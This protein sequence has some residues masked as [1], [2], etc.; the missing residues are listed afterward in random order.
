[1]N[2]FSA[3]NLTNFLNLLL[4]IVFLSVA[5][6]AFIL[7][8]NL[9]GPRMF[10]LGLGM[11]LAAWTAIADFSSALVTFTVNIAWFVSI[12]QAVSFSF[13]LLS[14][15]WNSTIVLRRLMLWQIILSALALF[16]FFLSPAL[17]GF[18]TPMTHLL[19]SSVRSLMCFLIFA[20]YISVFIFKE[21]RFLLLISSAFLLLSIGYFLL[22]PKYI[23]SG[24]GLLDT[25]GDAI[26]IVGT[27]I[28]FVA[29]TQ[30]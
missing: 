29:Y 9:R 14:I 19:V 24:A 30:K 6:R 7:Y 5:V 3:D 28:M 15:M 1:M 18:P 10:I 27:T 23:M 11:G 4:F 8:V 26:R 21:T 2:L 12:G 25:V 16:L 20:Y 17:P 22:L 13:L